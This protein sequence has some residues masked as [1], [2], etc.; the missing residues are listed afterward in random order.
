MLMI[1][2]LKL[3]GMFYPNP[4]V[5]KRYCSSLFETVSRKFSKLPFIPSYLIG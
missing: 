1:E 3:D 2:A 5:P 4:K